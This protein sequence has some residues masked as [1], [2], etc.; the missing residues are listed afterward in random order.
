M[1][2][3]TAHRCATHVFLLAR[4]RLTRLSLHPNIKGNR[5]FLM[6]LLFYLFVSFGLL[7]GAAHSQCTAAV[8]AVAAPSAPILDAQITAGQSHITGT[9][10]AGNM[11]VICVNGTLTGTPTKVALNG[12]F[13]AAMNVSLTSGQQVTAQQYTPVTAGAPVYSPLSTAVTVGDIDTCVETLQ[14]GECQF[15]IQIDTSAVVGNGSQSNTNTTP[16]IMVTLDYQFH[17]P[18]DIKG[19]NGLEALKARD[20]SNDTPEDKHPSWAAHL[21]GRTGYTQTFAATSVQPTPTSGGTAPSCPSNSK[22]TSSANC[23][24]AISKPS[25]IAEL[26]GRFGGTT[27]V[28]NAGFYGEYGVGG[29]GSF[30]YLIPTNQIVQNNGASYIDL[31]STNPHNAV[32]FYEIMGYALVAQHDHTLSKT[33]KA[34]NSSPLL[35]IEGGYQN[36]R[37]LQQLLPAS[38]QS[39]RNRYVGRFTFN[40]EVSKSTH[41]QISLGMEYSGGIN[42]GPHVVQIFVGGNLNPAKLFGKKGG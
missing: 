2:D 40:Y 14:S 21:R 30:Q 24:L 9:A 34:Q 26:A 38:P 19:K 5:R 7:R 41:S 25:F 11:V 16:N 1:S 31:N 18:Q 42:G 8:A 37:A 33:K 3:R 23:M 10:T 4:R 20:P 32:G 39:T 17:P 12:S 13:Q 15:R 22:S 6:H 27:G 28:D 36:N 35:V 29:R